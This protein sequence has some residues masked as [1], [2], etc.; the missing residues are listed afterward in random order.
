[1]KE[2]E[3]RM[4]RTT[5]GTLHIDCCRPRANVRFIGSPHFSE[6]GSNSKMF[7]LCPSIC[8]TVASMV[9]I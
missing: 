3:A 5:E 9:A 7:G 1:M 6:L 4:P 8:S 2:I